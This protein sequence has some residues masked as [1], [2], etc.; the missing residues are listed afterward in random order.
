MKI[1]AR[2]TLSIILLL[3][4][5]ISMVQL[6]SVTSFAAEIGNFTINNGVLTKYNG[7][8]GNV[9]IP[10]DAK[11]I[12]VRAFDEC[13][14]LTK[15]TI[16]DSVTAIGNYAFSNCTGLKSVL[17]PSSV[18]SIGTGAFEECTA[19][20]TITIP[21][22]VTSLGNYVFSNCTGLKS[23]IL[24]N[25]I[26]SVGMRTFEECTD[27]I[28]ITIPESVTAIGNYAFYDCTSLKS[29]VSSNLKTIGIK[30]FDECEKVTISGYESTLTQAYAKAYAI[31]FKSLGL[32]ALT[33]DTKSYVIAPKVSY[34][35]GTKLAGGTGTTVKVASS[36][37][38]V[39]KVIKLNNGGYRVTSL[40]AGTTN[41][42]FIVY[43]KSNKKLGQATVKIVVQK[44]VKSHGD[45]SNQVIKF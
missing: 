32:G 31:P 26:K 17:L 1:A 37:S 10:K 13:T 15:I 42:T 7:A 30:V 34:V 2:K 9:T 22:S 23:I 14:D 36:K 43:D 3:A 28:K 35:I 33:L 39:A 6:G 24:S 16:P 18:K 41:I 11:S 5:L 12:G 25:N 38:S 19:L 29:I 20:T 21:N 45:A 40:K 27:L 8:G 44:N 4:M